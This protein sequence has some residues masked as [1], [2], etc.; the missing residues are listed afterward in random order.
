MDTAGTE[1]SAQDSAE[2]SAGDLGRPGPL[3]CAW[4]GTDPLMVAYHDDEWGV[5][6]HDDHRHFGLLTLEGAQAGL[7]WTTILRKREGYRRCFEGFDPQRVAG[8][9]DTDVQ[10]LLDDPAIVRHRGKIESTITNA[11]A[12]LAVA[13]EFGTF[14]EYVW[15]FVG[16]RPIVGEWDAPGDLPSATPESAALS[17]DLKRRGF[18]F[19]G[20]TT[21]YAYLQAAGLVDDHVTTCFRRSA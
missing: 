7:S 1:D 15:E 10:R 17:R 16:G 2:N 21:V 18:R 20:P 6:V 12:L 11:G 4:A 13:D 5:P 9:G 3:R 8:F 19:V 14:D